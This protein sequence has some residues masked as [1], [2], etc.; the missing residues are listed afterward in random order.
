M[1]GGVGPDP[2]PLTALEVDR[3]YDG[4]TSEPYSWVVEFSGRCI[5]VARLHHVDAGA[6][7]A[8]YAIG[9]SALS[10]VV[11]ALVRRRPV[12]CST[13]HLEL[14]VSRGSS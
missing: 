4:L 3:W 11:A 14:L 2:G 8:R 13:T 12:L 5:G 6:R 10:T 1:V 7:S 9:S